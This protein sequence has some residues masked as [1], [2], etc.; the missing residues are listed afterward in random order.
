MSSIQG[1]KKSTARKRSLSKTGQVLRAKL[2]ERRPNNSEKKRKRER[3]EGKERMKGWS[4]RK[5]GRKNK[6][7]T[8]GSNFT[9]ETET[10]LVLT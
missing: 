10:Q 9:L 4:E 1:K 7:P 2:C 3:K 6:T 5:K 8:S